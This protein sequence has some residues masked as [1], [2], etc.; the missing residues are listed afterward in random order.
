ML[1]LK[2]GCLLIIIIQFCFK[3][4][5][6]MR[7]SDQISNYQLVPIRNVCR[8]RGHLGQ[9]KILSKRD[10][11]PVIKESVC[12][13]VAAKWTEPNVPISSSLMKHSD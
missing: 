6:Y 8:R 3:S 12:H 1:W 13:V 7:H 9:W 2:N 5:V 4:S 11:E 10:S